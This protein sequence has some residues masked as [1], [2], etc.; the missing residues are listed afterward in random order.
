[1]KSTA[2]WVKNYQS[3]VD[4]GR[5][6]SV[7][8]DLPKGKDGDDIGATALEFSVMALAG[9]I[10]TIYKVVANKMRLEYQSLSVEV[11]AEKPD[12]AETII[13]TTTKVTVKSEAEYKKLKRCLDLT[14]NTCPVGK[15]FEKANIPNEVTLVREE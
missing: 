4:N 15:L 13:K 7:V 3:V 8:M 9:C 6:H 2:V 5:T 11:E 14:L 10:A 1:M 12:D